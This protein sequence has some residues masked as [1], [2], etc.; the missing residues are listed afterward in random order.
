MIEVA[1]YIKI[2]PREENKLSELFDSVETEDDM[3]DWHEFKKNIYCENIKM[4]FDFA[5]SADF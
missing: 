4:I 3:S 2:L 5:T 1:G